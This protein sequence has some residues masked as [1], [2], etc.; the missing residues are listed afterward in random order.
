M[1]RTKVL[2][3]LKP[4]NIG[5]STMTNERAGPVSNIPPGTM[6]AIVAGTR[7]VLVANLSGTFFAIGNM[8]THMGCQLSQGTLEGDHV[9]CPCHGSTFDIRTGS[10]VK[11]P[12]RT[13]EKSYKV[14]IVNDILIVEL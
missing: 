13:A 4:E 3:G 9:I 1:H 6:K 14:T 12:A 8:C 7:E 5:K 2:S 10:V 11:G